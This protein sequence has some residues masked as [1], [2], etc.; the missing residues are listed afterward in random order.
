MRYGMAEW[1]GHPDYA[2]CTL[3]EPARRYADA[4]LARHIP[5]A[6]AQYAPA[7]LAYFA[8]LIEANDEAIINGNGSNG[9][10]R[11]ARVTARLGHY[12]MLKGE[13]GRLEVL[14]R[15]ERAL[16]AARRS[17][18]RLGEA[19][20]LRAIGDVLQFRKESDAALRSYETALT[21]YRALGDRLGEANTLAAL[22]RLHLD[23]DPTTSSSCSNR[24]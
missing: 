19:N 4:R 2:Q 22:S 21:L 11:T 6:F 15:L 23:I 10:N 17:N 5:D 16:A 18:D 20:T 3:L 14:A 12:W 7:T 24:H 9:V 13:R 1:R 8:D